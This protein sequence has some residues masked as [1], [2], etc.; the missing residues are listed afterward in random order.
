[1]KTSLSVIHWSA[2]SYGERESG[3][4]LYIYLHW[5]IYCIIVKFCQRPIPMWPAGSML[6]VQPWILGKLHRAKLFTG[7]NCSQGSCISTD[8]CAPCSPG[9]YSS[10]CAQASCDV[11]DDGKVAPAASNSCIPCTAGTF[12]NLSD[13]SPCPAGSF[14][15]GPTS[16]CSPCG[17]GKYNPKT[18]SPSE[19][20]CI[21]CLPG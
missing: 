4:F 8:S 5:T 12:A 21:P 7:Q 16:Q 19:S 2:S 20:Y 11:C 13:C 14:S 9:T 17:V 10:S 15:E 6:Y 1:M 18:S 3:I